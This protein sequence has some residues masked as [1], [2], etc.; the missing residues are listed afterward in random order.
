MAEYDEILNDVVCSV[1]EQMAF[2][3]GDPVDRDECQSDA[4][5]FLKVHMSFS[6][7]KSGHVEM[8]IENEMCAII[9]SNVLGIDSDDDKAHAFGTDSVKEM[10]NVICGQTLTSI[11][12]NEPIFNLSVP[13]IEELKP[14]H[15][16]K[17][18][19]SETYLYFVV[20]EYPLLCKFNM[21]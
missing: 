14:R 10:L 16:K 7:D 12:G 3:F 18:L 21:K 19:K 11:A 6:G 15:W 9:A 17:L 13:D 1:F 8:I 4:D 5:K 20:D 2:M